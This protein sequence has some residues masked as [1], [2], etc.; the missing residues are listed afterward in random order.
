MQERDVASGESLP[1]W[2]I[3]GAASGESL[4]LW[5]IAGAASGESLPLWRIAG[6]ASGKGRRIAEGMKGS[7]ELDVG[8]DFDAN[9]SDAVS[10]NVEHEEATTAVDERFFVFREV[11]FDSE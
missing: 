3:A 6:A 11:T 10:V 7:R 9:R 1:L 4:P 5:R 8:H 2:R